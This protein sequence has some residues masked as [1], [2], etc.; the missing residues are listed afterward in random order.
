MYE[1]ARWNSLCKPGQYCFV[2]RCRVSYSWFNISTN[3]KSRWYTNI[4]LS[5]ETDF[6]KYWKQ[7]YS[8]WKNNLCLQALIQGTILY[9]KISLRSIALNCKFPFFHSYWIKIGNFNFFIKEGSSGSRLPLGTAGQRHCSLCILRY[10]N[11]FSLLLLITTL[12]FV[13]SVF[14]WLHS[15]FSWKENQPQKYV[16]YEQQNAP[17]HF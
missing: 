9:T 3:S 15:V 10:Q 17:G 7:K 12:S 8:A 16:N 11:Q 2:C 6:F 1:W 5:L 4:F 13:T 14:S